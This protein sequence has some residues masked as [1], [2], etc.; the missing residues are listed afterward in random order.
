MGKWKLPVVNT[1]VVLSGAYLKK[2]QIVLPT[3]HVHIPDGMRLISETFVKVDQGQT[4]IARAIFGSTTKHKHNAKVHFAGIETLERTA[5]LRDD[6][7][8]DNDDDHEPPDHEP[9]VLDAMRLLAPV[10][11]PT[12]K[13]K[14]QTERGNPPKQGKDKIYTVMMPIRFDT[15]LDA[16]DTRHIRVYID[17]E[18]QSRSLWISIHDVTWLLGY[19]RSEAESRPRGGRHDP[20][21]DDDAEEENV[22]P[23]VPSGVTVQFCHKTQQW[24]AMVTAKEH[25]LNGTRLE[26]SVCDMNL[27][28]WKELGGLHK[29]DCD[30]QKATYAQ[31]HEATRCWLIMRM[32][33]LV[34][35]N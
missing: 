7:N 35:K 5:Q 26:M 33:S 18:A 2:E 20:C 1:S 8:A 34:G 9:P 31:R 12:A 23:L 15:N 30:F 3:R 16:T 6:G 24:I 10:Q 11:E 17:E 25:K 4:W 29:T 22:D 14:K 13:K 21:E 28:K 32:R 19:L 27:V